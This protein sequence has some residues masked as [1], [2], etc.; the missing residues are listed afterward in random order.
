MTAKCSKCKEV[1]IFL[2]LVC[3]VLSCCTQGICDDDKDAKNGK[4]KP[5]PVKKLQGELLRVVFR[6]GKVKPLPVKKLQDDYR[7]IADSDF[8]NWETYYSNDK[9]EYPLSVRSKIRQLPS[10]SDVSRFA[11]DF[12]TQAQELMLSTTPTSSNRIPWFERWLRDEG[13]VRKDRDIWPIPEPALSNLTSE[14]AIF[15]DQAK[16]ASWFQSY[17]VAVNDL[18]EEVEWKEELARDLAESR[19]IYEFGCLTY[20]LYGMES[21]LEEFVANPTIDLFKGLGT[22]YLN[23]VI[24]N[25]GYDVINQL[26]K[27]R[28]TRL[29]T[30]ALKDWDEALKDPQIQKWEK[31]NKDAVFEKGDGYTVTVGDVF[32]I[33]R[34]VSEKY[35]SVIKK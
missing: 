21:A 31:E 17:E 16:V 15:M 23:T 5:L 22:I 28:Y 4:V 9:N 2:A 11:F 1:A 25:E 13:D 32:S 12:Y 29:F 18:P 6:I 24:L 10:Y 3:I 20:H 35:E 14:V 7:F 27:S 26:P 8:P 19:F 34:N 30:K 33:L